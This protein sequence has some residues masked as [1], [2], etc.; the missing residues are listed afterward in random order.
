MLNSVHL[1]TAFLLPPPAAAVHRHR[2]HHSPRGRAQHPRHPQHLQQR[3]EGE[4]REHLYIPLFNTSFN[5]IHLMY[6]FL[7][8]TNFSAPLRELHPDPQ[9]VRGGPPGRAPHPAGAARR[10]GAGRLAVRSR[11]LHGQQR[12]QPGHLV[13]GK[14][15]GESRIEFVGTT[16]LLY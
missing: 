12:R 9:P 10:D 3:A 4:L 6:I 7:Y 16:L 8:F 1:A 15:G 11:L 14:E 2:L 5:F 13:P